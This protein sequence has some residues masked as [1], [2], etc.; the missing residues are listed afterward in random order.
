[1]NSEVAVLE[2]KTILIKYSPVEILF[3]CAHMLEM[4]YFNR[5]T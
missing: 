1:M 4:P 5:K 2:Y 3:L